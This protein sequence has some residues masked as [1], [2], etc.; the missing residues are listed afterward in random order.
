MRIKKVVSV[1][2]GR[3]NCSER[4]RTLRRVNVTLLYLATDDRRRKSQ[5][6]LMPFEVPKPRSN[7]LRVPL[8]VIIELK[9]RYAKSREPFGSFSGAIFQCLQ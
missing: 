7:A 1:R 9:S 4:L 3:F 6:R 5:A 2:H 8:K